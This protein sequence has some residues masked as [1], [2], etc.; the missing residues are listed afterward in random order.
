MKRTGGS[1]A[2]QCGSYRL[3]ENREDPTSKELQLH[4]A[5]I[6]ALAG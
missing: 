6:P 4:V 3:R 5:V 2:A 1:V